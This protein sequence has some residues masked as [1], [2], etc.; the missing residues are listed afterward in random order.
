MP[1]ALRNKGQRRRFVVPKA[2]ELEAALAESEDLYLASSLREVLAHL[3]TGR[4]L[5]TPRQWQPDPEDSEVASLADVK[6]QASAKRALTIAATGG[7][8]LLMVGPPRHRE[9]YARQQASL[10]DSSDDPGRILA[11]RVHC[12]RFTTAIRV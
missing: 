7:H 3:A 10:A 5:A 2:C 8:N 9:D 4:P 12:I 11:D 1:T 6:G